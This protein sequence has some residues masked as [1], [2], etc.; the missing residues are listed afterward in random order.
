[1][2]LVAIAV[3]LCARVAWAAPEKL[4]EGVYAII[5]PDATPDW[6]NGNTL[7]VVG[8]RGVLVLDAN[9]LPS[10]ARADIAAI[11]KLTKAPVRWLVNSHWHYDHNNGNAEYRKAFPSVEIVAHV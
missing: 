4:A 8:E 10:A 9:Y 11:R 3:L 6:P 5:H 2:R 1:M 7:V